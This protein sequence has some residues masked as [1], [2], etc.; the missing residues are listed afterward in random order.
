MTDFIRISSIASNVQVNPATVKRW[1][2]KSSIPYS[3]SA[4]GLILLA[5][6]EADKLI[7]ILKPAP[8]ITNEQS[9]TPKKSKVR[10]V[11]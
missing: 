3:R 9:I 5:K 4:G 6:T 11:R 10:K 7:N 1:L 2:L 8:A